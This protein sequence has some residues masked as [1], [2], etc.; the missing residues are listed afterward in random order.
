M[1]ISSPEEE[2]RN[3]SDQNCL[4]VVSFSLLCFGCL[5]LF[6][7]RVLWVFVALSLSLYIYIYLFL[8]LSLSLSLSFSLSLLLLLLSIF[9]PTSS[10][11]R[12][13]LVCRVVPPT[14]PPSFPPSLPFFLPSLSFLF[15][16]LL[17]LLPLLLLLLFLLLF[18][19]LLLLLLLL[20]LLLLLLFSLSLSL[21]RRECVWGGVRLSSL[22]EEALHSLLPSPPSCPYY[23]F[24]LP[25]LY[26]SSLS[27]SSR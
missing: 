9:F 15:S 12:V 11:G 14:H 27:L 2:Q 22:V 19:L 5:L 26:Y 4:A 17:L 24:L 13:G 18:L 25:I 21:S 6:L 3:R 16:Q 23:L 10:W 20:F 1:S 8:S 7:A